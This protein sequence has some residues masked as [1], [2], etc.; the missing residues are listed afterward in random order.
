MHMYVHALFSEKKKYYFYQPNTSSR[1]KKIYPV[2]FIFT[3]TFNV[4]FALVQIL[5]VI[6][7]QHAATESNSFVHVTFVCNT[8]N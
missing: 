3:I 8:Q 1:E 6:L 2:E 5:L 4:T 7:S